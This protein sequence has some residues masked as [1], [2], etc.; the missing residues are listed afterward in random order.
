MLKKQFNILILAILLVIFTTVVQAQGPGDQATEAGQFIHLQVATFDPLADGEPVGDSLLGLQAGAVESPYYIVQFNGPVEV[1]WIQQLEQ[2]GAEVLGYIPDNAHIVRIQPQDVENIKSLPAVRWMGSYRAGYKVA[3]ALTSA[4]SS[5]STDTEVYVIA[6]PGE[7]QSDLEAFLTDLGATISDT[8]DTDLGLSFRIRISFGSLAEIAQNPAISWIEPYIPFEVTNDEA[9]KIMNVESIWQSKGFFGQGQV[10]AVSDTG[11]SVQGNLNADFD[12]R[13]KRAFAPSEMNLTAGPVC[14]DVT[15]WTD[16]DGHGTHVSGSVLGNGQNSGSNPANHDYIGSFAG[17]APEAELVFM[18]LSGAGGGLECISTNGSFIAK[19]YE[20][21]ARISSNSWGNNNN[22]YDFLSSVVDNYIWQNKDYLVLY[23]AGNSGP[24]PNT[25]GSPGT[26][27]NI[28]S[29]GASENNRPASGSLSDNPDTMASFSSRGPTADGRIKPD[30]VAPGTNVVSVRGE[31]TPYTPFPANQ[32]YSAVSGTSMATPLTAGASAVVRE[33]LVKERNV[34]NPSAALLKALMVHGA[35]QLPG[36]ATP[37]T[38]SGWGRV[39]VKNTIYGEYA[40]FDDHVQGLST[41]QTQSYTLT[42]IGA[43]ESGTLFAGPEIKPGAVDTLD[44]EPQKPADTGITALGQSIN[45]TLHPL[46]GFET[47]AHNG[48]PFRS[49]S[50]QDKSGLTPLGS[51]L[52]PPSASEGF[53]S[54][55]S[56]KPVDP[57]DAT[58]NNFLVNLVGGGNF[59]DPGWTNIWSEIWLGFGVPVRTDTFA[60]SGNHSMW[61]GGTPVNDSVWYPLYLPETIASD[62]DSQLIFKVQMVDQD[63]GFDQFCYAFTDVSGFAIGFAPVCSDNGFGSGEAI[64]NIARTLS[65]AEKAELAGQTGYLVFF[66]LGDGQTPHMSAFVDDIV[67]N[68]DFEDPTLTSTPSSGPPGSEFLLTGNNNTPYGVVDVCEGSCPSGYLGTIFADANGDVA[69]LLGVSTDSSPGDI[70]IETSDANFRTATTTI[71]ILTDNPPTLDITPTSGEAGTTFSVSGTNFIPDDTDVAVRVNG[72]FLGTVGSNDSGAVAFKLTTTSNTPVGVYEVQV[73]DSANRS[74]TDSFEVT[75][76]PSGNPTMSVTPTAGPPG[77]A[78]SFTGQGFTSGGAVNFSLDGQPV[79]QISAD[80]SGN[81]KVQLTTQSTT[82]PGTYTLLA[83]QGNKQASAQFQIIGDNDNDTPQT[84]NGLYVTLVWTDPPA[85][86]NSST[87]SVN[88]LNL[89]VE[90][91]GGPYH[92]NGGSGPDTR[93]NVET[94]RLENPT[95]GDYTI[96]V[97]AASVNGLFG[98]QPYALVATTAQ[99][100]GAN[101]ATAEL[102]NSNIYLPFILK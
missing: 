9:R 85:Q 6:F 29:V 48:P 94:I 34:T 88:N 69:A 45:L 68:I 59:E 49:I 14:A 72:N 8:A 65:P 99:N 91:P 26:A 78:F 50:G 71:T 33:W 58:T 100:F 40:V 16:R 84:G 18:A 23:A 5:A 70:I 15:T 96:I 101:T 74:A 17:N 77:T 63:I 28:I 54:S 35:F 55:I 32:A 80:G 53:D 2:L 52:T 21:G 24:G 22:G 76:I 93:N 87:P 60:I 37:N 92:G 19:G 67:L 1:G 82:A 36:A 30:I 75:K 61:L 4:L 42:V 43:T 46:P 12:G 47:A 81:F 3:P 98:A 25:V 20:E 97:E 10:V 86:A 83:A 51:G 56:G 31:Q 90:G 95:T 11:L 13:L 38:N 7:S 39:D 27:K 73:T 89:R 79:G 66:N 62:F 41:G 64:V 102:D 44:F 57:N